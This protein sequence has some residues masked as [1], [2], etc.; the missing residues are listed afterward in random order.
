MKSRADTIQY[1]VH[2]AQGQSGM[3]FKAWAAGVAAAYLKQI[4]KHRQVVQFHPL[5]EVAQ[6][7]ELDRIMRLNAQIIRRMFDEDEAGCVPVD[8][9]EFMVRALPQPHQANLIKALA[10]RY[11]LLAARAP[12]GGDYYGCDIEAAASL[13]DECGQSL[14]KLAPILAD[15]RIDDNDCA[16]QKRDAANQLRGT[17]AVCVSLAWAL[18]PEGPA[19]QVVP[20]ETGGR[21]EH[22]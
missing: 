14:K 18:D 16:Q 21:R 13:M 20:L 2:A 3:K 7:D 22:G 17:M 5:P 4:P 9:E 19:A 10:S 8:L 15:G 12:E 6:A 1:H 11:G